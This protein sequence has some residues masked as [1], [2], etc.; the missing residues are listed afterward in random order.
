MENQNKELLK[1]EHLKKYFNTPGG[2]LHAVDDVSFSIRAG[3]TLGVV[4]ESGCGKSTMGR[5]I[6]R[7]H[8]PTSGKVS[9]EGNDI[10]SYEKNKIKEAEKQEPQVEEKRPMETEHTIEENVLPDQPSENEMN[11]KYNSL[12]ASGKEKMAKA[13][14]SGAKKDLSEAKDTKLTE[15]VVR[16]IIA[17]DEKTEEKRIADKKALY[18]EKM[19]FGRYKIVRKKSNNRYGAIDSKAEERIPCKYLSVGIADNGRAFE[20]ED[21]LFD[22]YNSDGSL[23]SEGLTYY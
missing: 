4:G 8:E 16:L 20:R 15:E 14:Y 19:A 5:A 1:V 10:L 2:V 17:C 21:N 7:L 3:E 9:F 12:I 22:I 13:D 18:E 11:E 6:L 23:I